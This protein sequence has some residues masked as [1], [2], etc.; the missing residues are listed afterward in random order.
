MSATNEAFVKL[1]MFSNSLRSDTFSHYMRISF[2]N[3]SLA[4]ISHILS[5]MKAESLTTTR[6]G[7]DSVTGAHV[8][9]DGRWLFFF[10][11]KMRLCAVDAR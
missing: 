10:F 9:Q 2:L 6:L 3:F 8:R 5:K 11:F 7:L 1:L 4:P